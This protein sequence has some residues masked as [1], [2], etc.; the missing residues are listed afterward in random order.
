MLTVALPLLALY[1]EIELGDI[2][3]EGIIDSIK[4]LNDELTSE[5]D[6]KA[7]SNPRDKLTFDN[8]TVSFIVD[9]FLENYL[10]LH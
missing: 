3:T 9:E 4:K 1:C 6:I 7:W 10:T 8:L 5:T 2:G